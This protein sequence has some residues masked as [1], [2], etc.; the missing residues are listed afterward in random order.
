MEPMTYMEKLESENASLKAEFEAVWADYKR[1]AGQVIRNQ[2]KWHKEKESMA[3]DLEVLERIGKELLY[4]PINPTGMA[5]E[6]IAMC[7]ALGQELRSALARGEEAIMENPYKG[8]VYQQGDSVIAISGKL[9]G[10]TGVVVYQLYEEGKHK[11][12]VE[13]DNS[14][15]TR[16][17]SFGGRKCLGYCN[18]CHP[19]VLELKDCSHQYKCERCGHKVGDEGCGANST[20]QAALERDE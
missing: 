18:W 1:A 17:A 5:T 12:L 15:H 11:V 7:V 16:Q 8:Y 14:T 19:S 3:A 13:F 20:K 10:E 6:D 2:H 4:M 9:K